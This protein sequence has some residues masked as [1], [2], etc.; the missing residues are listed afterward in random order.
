MEFTIKDKIT[1][2]SVIEPWIIRTYLHRRLYN[3][4]VIFVK[5]SALLFLLYALN[6]DSSFNFWYAIVLFFYFEL[7]ILY[8]SISLHFRLK[9]VYGNDKDV[10]YTFTKEKLVIKDAIQTRDILMEGFTRVKETR[11]FIF[12]Y[13]KDTIV[14]S[15]Y[16]PLMKKQDLLKL[17]EFYKDMFQDTYFKV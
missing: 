2:R 3:F 15:F 9:N 10:E 8:R 17:Q 12:V 7:Y 16:K 1:I 5:G 11:W 4:L 6:R 14:L 13:K